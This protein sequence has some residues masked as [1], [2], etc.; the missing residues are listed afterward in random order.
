MSDS[1]LDELRAKLTKSKNQL[2]QVSKML[3]QKPN[4]ETVKNL[5]TD[6]ER[7]I[8]LTENLLKMKEQ[9]H[10]ESTKRRG[11]RTIVGPDGKEQPR[12][13]GMPK[14]EWKIGE[15]CQAKFT[16]SH[17][18]IG[19]ITDIVAHPQ[20]GIGKGY[21]ILFLEYGDEH[22]ATLENMR[23]YVPP[24]PEQVQVGDRVR[25]CWGDD[26]MFYKAIIQAMA[27]DGKYDVEFTKYKN[28]ASVPLEDIQL[29]KEKKAPIMKTVDKKGWTHVAEEVYIPESL[30]AKPKDTKEVLD[31]KRLKKRKLKKQ[32]RRML[33]EA[34]QDNR[35]NAW[36]RF[37]KKGDRSK[38][39]GIKANLFRKAKSIFAAP[40]SLEGR[41]GV[42]GSGSGMTEFGERTHFH[43]LKRGTE[44]ADE[45]N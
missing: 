24:L 18:Y 25:A 5:K 31:K 8:E 26:G 20:G 37:K 1:S 13:W 45:E 10:A 23:T 12:E 19:A 43:N 38:T 7:V 39:K 14:D 9:K 29:V 27:D 3:A 11:R 2:K 32:H 22:V 30:R 4:N 15:R 21:Q 33:K 42:F 35:Q 34:E 28:K 6:L 40:E 17:W 36:K 16:D 41:V 44:E